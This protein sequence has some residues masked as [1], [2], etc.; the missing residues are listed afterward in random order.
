[1]NGICKRANDREHYLADH[2]KINESFQNVPTCI[3]L[4]AMVYEP[5]IVHK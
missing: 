1:M 3:K 4:P 2:L 5:R